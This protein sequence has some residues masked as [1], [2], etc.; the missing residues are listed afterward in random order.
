[1][2]Y[3]FGPLTLLTLRLY[4]FINC[5]TFISIFYYYYYIILYFYIFIN[6]FL[7]PLSSLLSFPLSPHPTYP[8]LLPMS[9]A[10][11]ISILHFFFLFIFSYPLSSPFSRFGPPLSPSFFL[12]FSPHFPRTIALIPRNRQVHLVISLG[13]LG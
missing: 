2:Y 11:P 7:S 1:M 13:Y 4:Y 6:H 3:F 10:P 9:K 12:R 5:F 8:H